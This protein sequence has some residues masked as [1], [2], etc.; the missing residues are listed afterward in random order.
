MQSRP[1]ELSDSLIA[2]AVS[3][4]WPV[5]GAAATYLPVGYGSHHW[6]IDDAGGGRWFASVD[7][8]DD[9]D[10]SASFGRLEAALTVAVRA[11]DAGLTF[12]VAPIRS[13][14]GDVLRS[15]STRYALALYPHVSGRAGQ[16]HDRLE[17]AAAI[18]LTGMLVA[19]HGLPSA[20]SALGTESYALHG[21]APLEAALGAAAGGLTDGWRGP[22]AMRLRVLLERHGGHV[23]RALREH[24]ALVTSAPRRQET[25]VVT[26]GEPHPG[27]LIRTTTGLALID[28]ETALLAP[29]ER[30]LWLL[31]ARTS[32]DVLAEYE[33]RSG[34]RVNDELMTRYRLAWALTDVGDFTEQLANAVE[35]TADTVWAWDALVGT[36]NDLTTRTPV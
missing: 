14:D 21:R 27:N 32:P 3:A 20:S 2:A 12:P 6:R 22:Y 36:V 33:G 28:W 10:P 8:L 25:M 26:H 31:Q 17:P 15:L 18:E 30:D 35:E 1:P 9:A 5:A 23:I 29:P 13:N 34:R 24:D 7:L 4:H 16:F 11:R 19:L